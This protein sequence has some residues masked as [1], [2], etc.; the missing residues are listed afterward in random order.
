MTAFICRFVEDAVPFLIMLHYFSRYRAQKTAWRYLAAFTAL[1]LG[2][3]QIVAFFQGAVFFSFAAAFG[4]LFSYGLIALR[5]ESGQSFSIAALVLSILSFVNGTTG[6]FGYWIMKR[7]GAAHEWLLGYME[8]LSAFIAAVLLALLLAGSQT[9]F[10]RYLRYLQSKT[11]FVLAFPVLF[12]GVVEQ[13]MMTAVYGDTIIWEPGKGLSYPVVNSTAILFMQ[14]SACASLAALFA[15]S[16]QCR[17]TLQLAQVNQ[18]LERQAKAQAVYVREA[19]T[20]ERCARSFRHDVRNHLLLLYEL[21]KRGKTTRALQYLARLGNF[22]DVK[23]HPYQT[24]HPIVD[25]LF[26]SKFSVAMQKNIAVACDLKLPDDPAIEDT[27]WCI[28]LANALDNAV[29]AAE[30]VEDEKRYIHIR[31]TR[32]GDFFFLEIENSISASH[33]GFQEGIGFAN[34]RSVVQKYH[35]L[36]HVEQTTA[37]F[38][39]NLLLI[40][41]HP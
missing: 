21:L 40:I 3:A 9:F 36:V 24:G 32:K 6:A 5:C 4:V 31:G 33:C 30:R 11:L 41:S 39:L 1:W 8:P 20:R 37:I 26:G 22:T 25:A 35:G 17:Q 15:L 29:R 13:V 2:L 28:L 18:I 12:I 27:D 14:A 19:Q 34:L 16:R 38:K 10:S 23:A 7:W